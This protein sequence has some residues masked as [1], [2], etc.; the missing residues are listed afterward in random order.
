ML[1]KVPHEGL[2]VIVAGHDEKYVRVLF[3]DTPLVQNLIVLHN[4]RI[5]WLMMRHLQVVDKFERDRFVL[6]TD[7]EWGELEQNRI[8][9]V[10]RLNAFN[11]LV[12]L[13]NHEQAQE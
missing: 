5:A 12:V 9:R 2:H 6:L 13:I 3:H 1:T 4:D 7:T 8:V 10:L 11:F